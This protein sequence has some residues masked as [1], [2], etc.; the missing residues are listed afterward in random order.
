[1]A[2]VVTLA[3]GVPAA[4]AAETSGRGPSPA[5]STEPD[6]NKLLTRLNGAKVIPGPGDPDGTGRFKGRLY[7]RHLCC[8][9]DVTGIAEPTTA[10]IFSG[11]FG[12]L[13]S[14]AIKIDLPVD[15]SVYRCIGSVQDDRD[16]S[17]KMSKS[18]YAALTHSGDQFYLQLATTEFPDGAIRGQL[19]RRGDTHAG[20]LEASRAITGSVPQLT[21]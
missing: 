14:P 15:G 13:G 8:Q 4:D 12:E 10:H 18:E 6:Q 9:F 11:V 5:M 2:M 16:T 17:D 21:R 7:L 20:S 1:M 3:L 19:K